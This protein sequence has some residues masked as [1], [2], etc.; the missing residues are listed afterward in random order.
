MDFLGLSRWWLRLFQTL[1]QS[2]TQVLFAVEVV[3]CRSG[4]HSMEANTKEG[5]CV[6]CHY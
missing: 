1:M 3:T 4:I 6:Q 2:C 5:F